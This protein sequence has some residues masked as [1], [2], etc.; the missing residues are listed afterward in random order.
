MPQHKDTLRLQHMLE[1]AKK[2]VGFV[3]GC[4]RQDLE[5]DEKLLLALLRLLEVVGEAAKNLPLE[6]TKKYSIYF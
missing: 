6:F 4:K 5:T 1:A 3:Q 2:A